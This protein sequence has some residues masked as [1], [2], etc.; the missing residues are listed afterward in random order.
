MVTKWKRFSRS[1]VLKILAFLLTALVALVGLGM[2]VRRVDLR[3]VYTA[4]P[5]FTDSPRYA[6]LVATAFNDCIAVSQEG[7]AYGDFHYEYLIRMGDNVWTNSERDLSQIAKAGG[8]WVYHYE[9]EKL[10]APDNTP[11]D[12]WQVWYDIMRWSEVDEM[13]L[14]MD[15]DYMA[16]R[17]ADYNRDYAFAQRWERF[18]W[19]AIAVLVLLTA[20]LLA[21]AG[22]TGRDDELHLVFVDRWPTEFLLGF[23]ITLA[24]ALIMS[25]LVTSDSLSGGR[26]VMYTMMTLDLLI[27]LV[28]LA[29]FLSLVRKAKAGRL[30]ADSIL[31]H[32][33]QG[34]AWLCQGE[35][36]RVSGQMGK[37]AV[38]R[39]FW[40]GILCLI[41]SIVLLFL[42]STIF[43]IRMI[44]LAVFFLVGLVC[45]AGWIY[46]LAMQSKDGREMDALANQVEAASAGKETLAA[47]PETSP[48]HKTSLQIA[49]LD[50]GVKESLATALKSER[51]K[52]ELITNVSHDLKTPL[53]SIIGYLDLLEKQ[54]LPAEAA[55]YVKILR[56]KSE[57]LGHT[58][59]DLFTLSKAT[60]GEETVVLEPLDLVM[61]V[62]QTL[63][64]MDDAVKKTG[65]PVRITL[66]DSAWVFAENRRL[67]RVLQNILDN[68]LRYSLAGTRIY[69]EIISRQDQTRLTLTNTAGYEMDFTEEE[70]LQR[71]VRGDKAR[72]T[73]GSGLGLSIAESFMDSFG[74]RLSVDIRG[75]S[76]TVTLTFASAPEQKESNPEE[77]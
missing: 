59:N 22:R 74:G 76:F 73:E 71:F 16:E 49:R 33:C 13:V 55:D 41:M 42:L 63:A 24:I 68:A 45:I 11:E 38:N 40:T 66:P 75:D 48:L 69:L 3:D 4:Y 7:S 25:L 2:T 50:A 35:T 57:R 46:L 12:T 18:F 43:Y 9:N 72:T 62:H 28:G 31:K 64:D 32:I 54:S 39:I 6:N 19:F 51:M 8:D 5:E 77:T 34:V 47:L 44:Y 23:L 58:V 17:V 29:V 61:A 1:P 14:I 26:A 21:V 30:W 67:Y 52:V 10:T 27:G 20:Y 37:R 56:K 36:W 15:S 60:S 70:I 65:I 53:T